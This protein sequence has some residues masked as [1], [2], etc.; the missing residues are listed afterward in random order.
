M[1]LHFICLLQVSDCVISLAVYFR[2]SAILE[3]C[4]MIMLIIRICE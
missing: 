4:D 3:V 2:F 1:L